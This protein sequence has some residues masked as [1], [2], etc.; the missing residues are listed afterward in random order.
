MVTN[1]IVRD[2]RHP[3]CATLTITIRPPGSNAVQIVPPLDSEIARSIDDNLALDDAAWDDTV[4]DSQPNVDLTAQLIANYIQSV[5]GCSGLRSIY[6]QSFVFLKLSSHCLPLAAAILIHRPSC[7]SREFTNSSQIASPGLNLK[8]RSYTAM[9]GVGFPFARQAFEAFGFPDSA[10]FPV[11]EQQ[12][13]DP[14]FPTVLFPNPEEKG[15]LVNYFQ[16]SLVVVTPHLI[17]SH[18]LIETR[19]WTCRSLPSIYR[20]RQRP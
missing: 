9:H 18:A 14:E 20:S 12:F 8:K 2:S 10:L 16:S 1:S 19:N 17:N 4:V 13:P 11:P 6:F 15:A 3:V 5:K 7:A